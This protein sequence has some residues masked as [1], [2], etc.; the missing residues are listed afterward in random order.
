M[1]SRSSSAS[2]CRHMYTLAGRHHP[3]ISNIHIQSVFLPFGLAVAVAAAFPEGKAEL[4]LR[5]MKKTTISTRAL[6]A[7]FTTPSDRLVCKNRWKKVAA[8][9]AEYMGCASPSFKGS[10][11]LL[12]GKKAPPQ[13]PIPPQIIGPSNGKAKS[14]AGMFVPAAFVNLQTT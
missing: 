5:A 2:S 11:P 9:S 12:M 10:K 6:S 13:P 3:F 7:A 1:H 14:E 4:R 8:M